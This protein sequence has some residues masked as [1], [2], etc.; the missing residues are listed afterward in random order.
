MSVRIPL[1]PR[2]KPTQ[3]KRFLMAAAPAAQS[4]LHLLSIFEYDLLVGNK[5]LSLNELARYEKA[6]SR[7]VLEE[8]SSCEVPA[9][10]GGGILRWI[11]PS[12]AIP[13]VFRFWSN[14]VAAIHFDG[15][16]VRSG[17]IDV[18]PGNHVLAMEVKPRDNDLRPFQIAIALTY[19]DEVSKGEYDPATSDEPGR[20]GALGQKFAFLS[21]RAV[22]ILATNQAPPSNWTAP[23]FQPNG[24]KSLEHVKPYEDDNGKLDWHL[25]RVIAAGAIVVGS[26]FHT[27]HLWARMAFTLH[28]PTEGT[29]THPPK[30]TK[31]KGR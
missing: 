2:P 20:V 3:K 24:W 1:H 4:A 9:G 27:P 11:D 16:Q 25:R 6:S 8:Y 21:G 10:C 12:Q 15:L 22:D 30:K 23:D 14:G 13:L 19:S 31:K 17:R 5:Q 29:V 28:L 18:S 7:L 26:P